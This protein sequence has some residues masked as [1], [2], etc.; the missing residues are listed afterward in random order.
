M[1]ITDAQ[2]LALSPLST[3]ACPIWGEASY[4]VRWTEADG[5]QGFA[6][7]TADSPQMAAWK[8]SAHAPGVTWFTVRTHG[9]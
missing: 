9:W 7:E 8:A 3:R 2:T 1:T 5:F 4:L 6:F